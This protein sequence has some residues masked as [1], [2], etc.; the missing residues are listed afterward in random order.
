[1]R[2]NYEVFLGDKRLLICRGIVDNLNGEGVVVRDGRAGEPLSNAVR[3]LLSEGSSEMV[4]ISPDPKESWKRFKSDYQQLDAAGGV[5]VDERGRLLAIRRLGVW[6]LPKGK[7]EKGEKRKA[8]GQREVEEEC[9]IRVDRV[10][11]RVYTTW[12][13]YSM[14]G[15]SILK[16]TD[17]YEMEASSGQELIPQKEEAI[18]RVEWLDEK[19]VEALMNDTY[20]SIR[21][22]VKTWRLNRPKP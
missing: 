18:Q 22:V 19:G 2:Q 10:G 3:S 8:G 4:F 14:N 21:Q 20:A 13:T 17:W 11:I 7:L 1:M 12:H 9:G 15:L 6:D 16:R 5:V